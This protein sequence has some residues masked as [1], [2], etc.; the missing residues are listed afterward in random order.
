MSQWVLF[1]L[2]FYKDI[3]NVVTDMNT[4]YLEKEIQNILKKHALSSLDLDLEYF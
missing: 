3:E 2:S 4:I 1:F